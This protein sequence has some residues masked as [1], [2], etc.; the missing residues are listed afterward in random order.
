MELTRFERSI[1]KQSEKY[2]NPK[3]K[4]VGMIFFVAG[5]LMAGIGGRS[6]IR[7]EGVS[8]PDFFAMLIGTVLAI[9][10]GFSV[11]QF[12]LFALIRKLKDSK[13]K[14]RSI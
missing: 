9:A 2:Q 11:Y 14:N 10:G 13:D 8:W 7:A 4:W 6:P 1:L 5:I 3:Y 12:Y